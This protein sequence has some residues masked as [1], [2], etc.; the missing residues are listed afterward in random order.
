[1][2]IR[3]H[4]LACKR[5]VWATTAPSIAHGY[6]R[7]RA[8]MFQAGSA[9]IVLVLSK[10]AWDGRA[11][12]DTATIA[13]F[14]QSIPPEC[15]EYIIWSDRIEF[16]G[17]QKARRPRPWSIARF[18]PRWPSWT[19]RSRPPV[20]SDDG[21][22]YANLDE[23]L[24]LSLR[25]IGKTLGTFAAVEVFSSLY[26]TTDP[27]EAVTREQIFGAL[28]RLCRVVRRIQGNIRLFSMA[29]ETD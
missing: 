12:L 17:S 3:E 10:N 8:R 11:S 20:R 15:I 26:A 16:A 23:W 2:K 4:G 29:E 14:H 25:R 27:W 21:E 9:M 13:R 1:M 7:A 19:T 6:T 24:D 18:K 22:P 5:G 28:R